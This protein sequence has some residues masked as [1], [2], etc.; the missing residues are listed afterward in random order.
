MMGKQDQ[1]MISSTQ[2]NTVHFRTTAVLNDESWTQFY[3][4]D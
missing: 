2:T 1:E 4:F 3:S